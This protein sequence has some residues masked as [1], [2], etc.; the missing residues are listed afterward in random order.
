[1]YGEGTDKLRSK[2]RA[3]LALFFWA[4]FRYYVNNGFSETREKNFEILEGK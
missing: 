1:M 3:I 2:I 4:K